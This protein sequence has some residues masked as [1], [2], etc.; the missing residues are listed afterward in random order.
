MIII[1]ADGNAAIGVGHVMRDL[2]VADALRR[3]G[4]DSLF[5]MADHSLKALVEGRGYEAAVLGTAYNRMECET[6]PLKA[7]ISQ[8]SPRLILV[9]SYFVT[10]DYLR[11]LRGFS[12]VAYIDDV[13]AFAYPVDLLINYNIFADRSEYLRLYSG[14]GEKTPAMLLGTAYAP[15]REEFKK[16]PARYRE[17]V[18]DIFVS[19]GGAD[20]EHVELRL[21][22]WLNDHCNAFS[23]VTFHIVVGAVN[24]DAD[25]II[26]RASHSDNIVIHQNVKDMKSLML[27]CDIAVS[28]AGSTLYELC[29]CGLPIVTYVIADNQM[30]AEREFV[31]RN[32]ALSAGDIR[33]NDAFIETLTE[34]TAGLICDSE[35]RRRL[36]DNARSLID[37]AGADA[38]AAAIQTE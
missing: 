11:F 27:S 28:A 30:A 13:M 4:E 15:L 35:K 26:Q 14:S 7:V 17:K 25:E 20:S 29:A 33:S 21:V 32:I 23:N 31:K 5:V 19:S 10:P 8:R 12:R 24:R 18:S 22:K 3:R 6:E 38:L 9:D 2:S 16:I 37:G 1:R 34:Q 36:S